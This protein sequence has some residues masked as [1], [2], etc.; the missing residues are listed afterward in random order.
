M[1]AV[2]LACETVRQEL[3]QAMA[4]TGRHLPVIWLTGGAHNV[5]QQ[6]RD[7]LQ[8]ALDALSGYDTVLLAMSLCGGSLLGLESGQRTLVVPRCDDCVTLL[9][10]PEQRRSN[11]GTY[12]L[13]EGWLQGDRNIWAEYRHC[14]ET[15]GEARAK[16]I[17]GRMFAHYRYLALVDTNSPAPET[18]TLVREIAGTLGLE[19]RFLN[20]SSRWLE[21]LLTAAFQPDRFLIVPPHTTVTPALC[22]GAGGS[23]ES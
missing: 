7:Q 6:R 12:F 15:H 20:G 2:I 5:P 10:G 1:E 3:E 9:L 16:R 21:E 23:H 19:Y 17:F 8:A 22:R 14:V 11:P 4:Q 18:E 13:T